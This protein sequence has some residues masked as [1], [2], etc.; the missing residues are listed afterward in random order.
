MRRRCSSWWI[1]VLLLALACGP[2]RRPARVSP[3]ADASSARGGASLSPQILSVLDRSTDPC[4]DF[5]RFACGGWLDRTEIPADRTVW[6]RGFSEVREREL[7]AQRRLLDEAAEDPAPDAVRARLGRFYAACMNEEAIERG[8]IDAIRPLLTKIGKIWEPM[9]FFKLVGELH[10]LQVPALFRVEIQGDPESP[11][12]GI[13]T[14]LRDGLGLPDREDYLRDDEGSRDLRASY[15]RHVARMLVALGQNPSLAEDGAAEVVRFE[16]ALA[17]IAGS[18]VEAPGPPGRP[19][20]LDLDSLKSLDRRLAWSAYLEGAGFPRMTAVRLIAPEGFV[21]LA[22]LL[23]STRMAALKAYV[24]WQL[25]HHLAVDLPRRIQEEDFAFYRETLLG[26]KQPEPRWKRCVAAT[27]H[28]LSDDLSTLYRERTVSE[29]VGSVA[30][31]VVDGVESAFVENL[32]DLS[33]MDE[34]TRRWAAQEAGRSTASVETS[35]VVLDDAPSEVETG[36]HLQNSLR[37]R[38]HEFYRM[39]DQAGRPLAPVAWRT[40]P[41]MANQ[42]PVAVTPGAPIVSGAIAATPFFD[43]SLPPPMQFGGMGTQIARDRILR[44]HAR[45][46]SLDASARSAGAGSEESAR[47]MDEKARCVE[48]F[49]DA[50]EIRPGVRLDGRRTLEENIADLGGAKLAYRAWRQWAARHGEPTRATGE[51]TDDQLFFVGLAQTLCTA[52]TPQTE[53]VLAAVD[54]RSP[55]RVRVNG[56]LANLPAFAQTFHCAEGTPMRPV[57]TCEVW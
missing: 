10:S 6:S 45:T 24:R 52:T 9:T 33:F 2:E 21:R 20:R 53:R 40:A 14:F 38:M 3:P 48:D 50:Y 15:Q 7:E 34:A 43:A 37:A 8:G 32:A 31:G 4:T 5:Y 35:S 46:Q 41:L 28:A 17:R 55:P 39:V 57:R 29:E 25:V 19:D 11:G 44:L 16:T 42:S 56:S 36:A 13:A 30:R 47:R 51:L 12:I 23:Q 22:D 1:G 49:F 18:P 54:P 27:G 26:Q